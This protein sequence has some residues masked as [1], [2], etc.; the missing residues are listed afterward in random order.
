MSE[1]RA[2]IDQDRTERRISIEILDGPI[3]E[4]EG[5][6]HHLVREIEVDLL[7]IRVID[8]ET[9]LIT[10]YGGMVRAD[11]TISDLRR[12]KAEWRASAVTTS[13]QWVQ[14]IWREAPAGV[15]TWRFPIDQAA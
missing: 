3:L 1:L 10:A 2:R 6:G 13:P 8:G 9:V 7:I 5:S 11:G 14:R 15:T 12:G 4:I